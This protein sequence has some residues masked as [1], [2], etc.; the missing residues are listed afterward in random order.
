ME[1]LH[2]NIPGFRDVGHILVPDGTHITFNLLPV[3]FAQVL[4]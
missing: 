3:L 4:P 1:L 2:G